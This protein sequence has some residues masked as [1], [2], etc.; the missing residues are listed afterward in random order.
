MFGHDDPFTWFFRLLPIGLFLPLYREQDGR[1]FGV[2][3][4]E[5]DGFY[6]PVRTARN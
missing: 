5:Y 2:F 4:S 1:A 3:G 6:L